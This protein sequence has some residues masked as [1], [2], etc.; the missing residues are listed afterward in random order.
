MGLEE[1]IRKHFTYTSFYH[2]KLHSFNSGPANG[3]CWYDEGGHQHLAV[4]VSPG[5]CEDCAEKNPLD[6]HLNITARYSGGIFGIHWKVIRK[7]IVYEV[8]NINPTEV[9]I[10]SWDESRGRHY[11]LFCHKDAKEYD[12]NEHL[13]TETSYRNQI[14]SK[15][16]N[17]RVVNHRVYLEQIYAMKWI[18]M[19]EQNSIE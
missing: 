3:E 1:H 8:K 2:S 18:T 6:D 7:C 9:Y 12:N 13:W 17:P 4:R 15:W 14:S 11:S 5:N 16:H 10:H 19:E